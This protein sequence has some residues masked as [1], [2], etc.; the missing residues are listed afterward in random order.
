MRISDWSS[1]VCSSD[2]HE[3]RL[4]ARGQVEFL[5]DRVHHHHDDH[6]EQI[7]HGFEALEFEHYKFIVADIQR[8]G[9]VEIMAIGAA[10]SEIAQVEGELARD[11]HEMVDM[12]ERGLNPLGIGDRKSIVSGKSVSV[13]VDL[14]GRRNITKKNKPQKMT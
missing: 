5:R 11:G 14:G 10:R 13:R 4:I 12:I 7:R 8:R 3:A 9:A 6:V 2:L 1:D